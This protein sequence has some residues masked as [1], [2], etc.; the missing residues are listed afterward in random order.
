MCMSTPIHSVKMRIQIAFQIELI[1]KK[2]KT[3]Y[4]QEE[5]ATTITTQPAVAGSSGWLYNQQQQLKQHNA[6]MKMF[7]IHC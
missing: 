7:I 4:A 2:K 5:A 6:N 3:R 1:T